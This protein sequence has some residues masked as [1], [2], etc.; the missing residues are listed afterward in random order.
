MR[1]CGAPR[2]W[3]PLVDPLAR[4]VVAETPEGY[5]FGVHHWLRRP[6]FRM[7]EQ[8][9]AKMP[10]SPVLDAALAAPCVRLSRDLSE[11]CLSP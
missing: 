1:G 3:P 2:L 6:R 8:V 7:D 11:S 10:P 4:V 9:I 5:R